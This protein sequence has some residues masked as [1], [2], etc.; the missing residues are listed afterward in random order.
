MNWFLENIIET[1]LNNQGPKF[2]VSL[3][4][5]FV[6]PA[7]ERLVEKHLEE[8]D[9]KRV[10]YLITMAEYGVEYFQKALI[11]LRA[12]LNGDPIDEGTVAYATLQDL[13]EYKVPEPLRE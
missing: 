8:D 1:I 13:I 12:I 2:L 7:I 3:V 4:P 6:T 9:K 10:I 5:S 11:V